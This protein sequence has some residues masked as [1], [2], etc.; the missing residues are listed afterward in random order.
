MHKFSYGVN[1]RE[2]DFFNLSTTGLIFIVGS[3]IIM[4]LSLKCNI[5]HNNIHLSRTISFRYISVFSI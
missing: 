3:L 1:D 2:K 5:C 4:L